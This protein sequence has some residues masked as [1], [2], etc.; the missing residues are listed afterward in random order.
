MEE[1]GVP[2]F[3]PGKDS[4]PI[5]TDRFEIMKKVKAAEKKKRSDRHEIEYF[6]LPSIVHKADGRQIIQ[7]LLVEKGDYFVKMFQE[8]WMR[9]IIALI[10][11]NS[12]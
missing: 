6:L 2:N 7:K 12:S 5:S 1:L 4:E 8:L 11:W 9:H 3:L 10:N